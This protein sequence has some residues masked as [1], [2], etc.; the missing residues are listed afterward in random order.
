MVSGY[1][2]KNSLNRNMTRHQTNKTN[3]DYDA[4]KYN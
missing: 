2:T 1:N 3:K 4:N